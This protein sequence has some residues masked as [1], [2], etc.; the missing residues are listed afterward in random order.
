MNRTA[1]ESRLL[2]RIRQQRGSASIPRRDRSAPAPLSF[3]QLRL[4]LLERLTPQSA[5]YLI[6]CAFRVHGRLDVSALETAFYGL[7]QR[8]EVLRT[9]YEMVGD[10]PVQV[11]DTAPRTAVKF[12]DICGEADPDERER[13]AL[14]TVERDATLGFDL[15]VDHPLRVTAVRLSE[16]E[17]LLL[18]AMHH[19]AVDGW[20]MEILTGELRELY[21]AALTGRPA[22]LTDLAVQYADYA[23]WQRNWLVG[24]VLERQLSYWRDRLANLEPLEMPTDWPRPSERSGAGSSLEF[25]VPATVV[26][27]LADIAAAQGC[28]LFM[29]ALASFQIVLSRWSGQDDIAVGSPIAGRNRAES[30]G[31]IGFFVNTLVLRT[32]LSGEPTFVELLGKVRETALDAYN[33]QDLPFER[34]VEELS[35]GRDLSRNPLFQIGFVLQGFQEISWQLPGVTMEPLKIESEYSK[36]DLLLALDELSNGE[37]GGEITFSTELFEM[38]TAQSFAT[39]YLCVLEQVTADPGLRIGHIDLLRAD[40]RRQFVSDW[41]DTVVEIPEATAPQLFAAQVAAFPDA[42]AVVFGDTTLTYAELDR[43]ANRLAHWLIEQGVGIEDRVAVL[44]PRSIELVVALL[45]VTKAGGAF[46]PLHPEW[47]TERQDWI[48]RQA[49]VSVVIAESRPDVT[50]SYP[51]TS[52]SVHVRP[53]QLVYVMYTSGSTGEPKGVA[54]RHRDVAALVMDRCWRGEVHQRVLV[55]SAHS[56]DASTYEMWVPLLNGGQAVLAPVG[57]LNA[58]NLAETITAAEITSL[59]LTTRLFELIADEDPGVFTGVHEV[60]T[61]GEEMPAEAVMRAVTACP[62]TRFVHVYGPTETTTFA[63]YHRINELPV[64]GLDVPI[65]RPLDNTRVF[66]LDSWLRLVPPGVVGELYVAGAGLARGYLGRSGLTAGRF[67]ADPFGGA[68]K[69]LYRTGDRVRW[70][71]EGQLVFVG[72]AD[73]QVKVRGFR[74]E[75]GEVEAALT[76]HVSVAQA[77]VVA[78]D[79]DAGKR[80]VGYVVPAVADVGVDTVVVREFVSARLPEY[81]V[82][83]ALVVLE[84]LPL[85]VNGKVDRKALPEPVFTGGVYRGPR[86]PRE[87]LLC[88]VFAEVLGVERVGIDDSFFDL[89]GHSLLATKLVSRVRAVLGV[90]PT[91]R[92]VFDAPTVAVLAGRLADTGHARAPLARMPRPQRVPLSFAQRRLWFLDQFEGP[93]AIYNMPLVMRLIGVLDVVGLQ[94]AVSDVV[95]RHESLRTII[96]VVDGEP[97]QR[98][99]TDVEP[100]FVVAEVDRSRLEEELAQAAAHTFDL[101]EEIP[102]R[103]WLWQTGPQEHVLA[104][105]IHHI[106]GDGWSLVP[107]LRDLSRAYAARSTGRVPEFVELPVQYA[108]YA[109]WQQELLGDEDDPGSVFGRQLE[110]WRHGLQGAPAELALPYDRSRPVVPTHRG[111][112]VPVQLDAQIHGEL[113]KLARA[114]DVTMFML[115]NAALA[116]LLSRMGGGDDIPVGAAMAGRGDEALDDLVGFFVNT[117]VLRTDL[118]GDPSFVEVLE[119]VREVNLG[120]HAHADVPF[121][122]V[123]DALGVE[124]SAARQP[125][126][127]VMLMLQNNAQADLV[128]PGL[129]LSGH[130][131]QTGVAKFDLTFSFAETSDQADTVTGLA[132]GVEYATDLFDHA[133]I[134]ALAERFTRVLQAVVTDPGLPVS[135]I[136]ILSDHERQQLRDWNDTVVEIPE[137]TAPQLFAAQV[138]AFP[139]AVAVVFGDT[140]LTYAELDRRANRLA[141]WL[142]EQGVGIED[143]VAVLLPRSIELVVALLAVTK[144]G[145]VYVPVDPDLPEERVKFVMHDAAPVVVVDT[146]FLTRDLDGYPDTEPVVAEASEERAVYVIYT[147]GSTGTPKGVVV[148]H[149]ALT[150]FLSAMQHQFPMARNDRFLAITTVSFD[151]AALEI[152]LPLISG[153]CVVIA[154]REATLDPR[155]VLTLIRQAGI[156]VMQATPAYW[157]VLVGHDCDSLNGLRVLTGGE[158]LPSPLAATMRE[159]AAEATNMYGPTET[160][161]WSMLWPITA[162]RAIPPIGKPIANTRI[163]VLDGSLRP[164][165]LGVSGELYVA[166]A[167]LARGYLGRAGLT[168]ARFV[169]DPFA[170]E[171]GGRL[172]RTGDLVRWSQDGQLVFVGRA[173]D[174]V[175]L[176]GFRIEPGEVETVLATHR[177]VRQA[178]VVAR[179]SDSGKR[180]VGYVVPAVAEVGVDT[181]AVRE[182]AAARLPEYMVPAALVVLEALPLNPNGK[183]DRKALPEPVFTG[184]VYRGPKTVREELLCGVFAEVLGAERVGIDDNFF[185]LGGHS[186]A[187]AKLVNRIR[188]VFDVELAL[189]EV[190]GSPTVAGLAQRID[191]AESA[192]PPVRA[193]TPRPE[194]IP[195]SYAQR[196]LWFIDQMDHIGAAYNIPFAARLGGALDRN[197]LRQAVS[198]VVNRHETLRTIFPMLDGEPIQHILDTAAA[199]TALQHHEQQLTESELEQ[200]LADVTSREF[201]LATE[202]PIRLHVFALGTQDHVLVLV[203]HHIAGDGWSVGPLMSDLA[204]AYEARCSGQVPAWEPLPV[205]YTDYI[206]WQHEL[207]GSESNPDSLLTRQLQFWRTTL[208]GAPEELA[209]PT[210][211]PRPAFQSYNGSS[212]DFTIDAE[213]HNALERLSRTHGAT[214]FMT[215][216]AGLAVLLTRLGSGTDLPIG[217]AVAGRGDQSLDGLVGF[218]VNTLVLRTDTSGDPTFTELLE[219][220]RETDLAAF[221]NQEVPFERV[222]EELNPTRATARH[223]LFQV[224]LLLENSTP[225]EFDFAGI[226]SLPVPTIFDNAKFDLLIGLT[227]HRTPEST[228]NGILGSIN[229]SSDLFDRGSAQLIAERF[230]RTLAAVVADPRSRVSQIDLL[231][232]AERRRMLLEWN[233]TATPNSGATLPELFAAQVAATPDATALRFED[234]TLTYTELNARANRLARALIARGAGPGSVVGVAIHRSV[235]LVVGIYATV[236]AGAAYLPINP[237]HPAD[238]IAGILEQANPLFV[239]TATRDGLTLPSPTHRLDIDTHDLSAVSGHAIRT[240]E[241]RRLLSPDHLAYVLFTSG[242]TGKPKG[243]GVSHAA[244]V[245]QLRWMQHE[246]PLDDSDVVV[247]KTSATFDVSVLEFFAPLL[248][249]AQLVVAAPGG[250]RDPGYLAT[251]IAKYGVT[252]AHFVP[253]MLSLFVADA[254]ARDCTSLRRVFCAGEALTS[255]TVRDFHT[256]LGRG[257]ELHNLYG[258]TEASVVVTAWPCDPDHNSVPIGGPSWNTQLYVLDERLRPVPPGV[259]GELYLAGVQLA[260]GYVGQPGLSAERFVANPFTVDARMYRTGDLVRWRANTTTGVLEYLGRA[261]FQVKLRG[262]RIELTEIEVVLRRHEDIER[263]AVVV[264]TDDHGNQRLIAY[265]VAA[266]ADQ[267]HIEQVRAHAA[268]TLPGYMVPSA[269]I[270]LTELPLNSNGKLDRKALPAPDFSELV[271]SRGPRTA[272]EE[273]LC[274]LF[275]EVLELPTVGID[276]NFFDLGGHSLLG[277]RLMTRLGAALGVEVPLHTLFT[278]PTV[279]RLAAKLDEAN[280]TSE[281][282]EQR[283]GMS[284][285][286]R[287][288]SAATP[289]SFAQLRLWLLDCLMPGSSAYVIASAFRVRGTL[290][291]EALESA[292]RAVA[293]RHEALRT[294]YVVTADEPVQVVDAEP[295]VTLRLVEVS[296]E[297][298]VSERDRIA[299]AAIERDAALAFDLMVDHPVRVTVARL[300]Q[301]EHLLLVALHHIAADG[302][303]MEILTRELATY[304]EAA[305]TGRAAELAALPVQYADYAAWQRNWLTGE[306]LNRQLGYWRERLADL[307]PLE[308]PT[309][310]SRPAERSGAGDCLRF[311][312]PAIAGPLAAIA[313]EQGSSLFMAT[314]AAFTIVLSRWSSQDDIAVGSPIAGRTRAETED[315][316]GFFVNTLVLRTDTSGDPTFTELLGRVRDATLGAYAHQDLPFERLVEELAPER[317][318]SRNPLFQIS[319]AFQ[320]FQEGRWALP[321]ADIEPVDLETTTSKFDLLIDLA[322]RPD[323]GL[324]GG[325]TFSTELFD[326]ATVRRLAGHYARVLEQVTTD[327]GL[328]IGQI[329]LIAEAERRDVLDEWNDTTHRLPD[330]TVVELFT[331]QARRRPDATAVIFADRELTYHQLHS[332]AA[333]LTRHLIDNGV[334]PGSIVAIAMPRSLEMMVALLGVLATGAA[335][336]PIDPDHPAERIRFMLTDAQPVVTITTTDTK[337]ILPNS[338]TLDLSTDQ[339]DT[340]AT[341]LPTEIHPHHLAY[342]IYTSGSTGTPKAVGIAHSGLT[343][344]LLWMQAQYQ[345]TPADRVIQKTPYGFDVSVWEFFWPMITGATL[346]MAAP[347]GHRD[348]AYLAQLIRDRSVTV[349]HF[350]PSMLAVFLDEPSAAEC[351]SVR[352]LTCSGEALPPDLRDRCLS[353][354]TTAEFHNLYG[355]TEASIDVTYW[356]CRHDPETPTVPIGRPL[357]NTR[358]YV[359]DRN[360]RPVPPGVVGML[361]VAGTGLARGYLNRPGLT[362]R[363]FVPNLFGSP[364]T[365]LY[366][367]GDLAR[368]HPRGYLEY[369]GRADD[370]VK[371]RGVRIEL[372]EIETTLTTHPHITQAAVLVQGEKGYQQLAAYLVPGGDLRSDPDRAT[373]GARDHLARYLP[374]YLIPDTFT[375]LDRMPLNPNGKLDRRALPPPDRTGSRGRPP[376]SFDEEALAELFAQ[377]LD[378][379]RVDV[380]DSFFALGGHSLLAT[381]LVSRIQMVLGADVSMRTLFEA[382]TVEALAARLRVG[383]R[384]RGLSEPLVLNANGARPPLFCF[385]PWVGISWCYAT[386]VRSLPADQPVYG[387]QS[388]GLDDMRTMPRSIAEAAEHHAAEIRS[389]RPNGP[390]LLL[391]WSFGGVVAHAVAARLQQQGEQVHLLALLDSHPRDAG[392]R[393]PTPAEHRDALLTYSKLDHDFVADEAELV[394]VLSEPGSA[395]AALNTDQRANLVAVSRNNLRIDAG[396]RA[397][398]FHGDILLFTAERTHDGAE[399]ARKWQSHVDG[400]VKVVPLDY[401]HGDMTEPRAAALVGAA[402]IEELSTGAGQTQAG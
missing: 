132:G 135:A 184:G 226:Q 114:H 228:P 207:L 39:R 351:T 123:V 388:R 242:S 60:W 29:A 225:D 198:D 24:E 103:A 285:P 64:R 251:L 275:A 182:F 336:L 399:T 243:V 38:A 385:A 347:D 49:A 89:G 273:V 195:L 172:Y 208:A 101:A 363:R 306:V 140:T 325:L 309:D 348:P 110:Y 124:R 194:P 300:A 241:R 371:I 281:A 19:I 290:D 157:Q 199:E 288:P 296:G 196:R 216:Q 335:Y 178:V 237:D 339:I 160:T 17:H 222:V 398:V 58:E 245:N 187:A 220:V 370:Q 12:I 126:F 232:E 102:L 238:R 180:L 133:T 364:G 271:S 230:V 393:P 278:A 79:S 328:R 261:D 129:T 57:T 346:V 191:S 163:F 372:G 200:A 154:S 120:A 310:R 26:R 329:D 352:L 321:G 234:E 333:Q 231:T 304:Y 91:L 264:H 373:R 81:M 345:L 366:D 252:T 169:A 40:E 1:V 175:K 30:E 155:S 47:P 42:V 401:A 112:H 161:I 59:F 315:L 210:D 268:A 387:L 53:D 117:V 350:V 260:R 5:E 327:P 56:F 43:R 316:I 84:A 291:V 337:T 193:V 150:N 382:P 374:G 41:N 90:E 115:L 188:M 32:D 390:Y 159:R 134:A 262:Q 80:L 94:A 6:P 355:P 36:F 312:V 9:R 164:V 23:A 202:L 342:I 311:E 92:M 254:K 162:A 119:R 317:D 322:E 152:F 25:T 223:P 3:A 255:D 69:R 359:L 185:D 392:Y 283:A 357:W 206:M 396:H 85:N 71:R 248:T 105:V 376:R 253:S 139:D 358:A 236:Q 113:L 74:I 369:R 383:E 362:A 148:S 51:H 386:L 397:E 302:W 87:E 83:A 44:L 2:A 293:R 167:G 109:L 144:A 272:R 307:E 61:G 250:H 75:P 276:D 247:Q 211:R 27:R 365:R 10:E 168:S 263:A 96:E 305:R 136:S 205:Q 4:W 389:I 256:A 217:S 28:S 11:I 323:G 266:T 33:H 378:V 204:T 138:A 203:L 353:M 298:D 349:A 116:V 265:L 215:M 284:I 294:R 77:V 277:V 146:A 177:G 153:A 340:T 221:N 214:I 54:V 125:L 381:R 338:I 141:H 128:L 270:S 308:L 176:R 320:N 324:D 147:S 68:G 330:T 295:R 218:F 100:V 380:S 192:R 269:F 279:A 400:I 145:G 166:G 65:G 360:L 67:V 88:G 171:P 86:T 341:D 367:T 15:A 156:T 303:S 297:P 318:L 391:G 292:F 127:Q 99:L 122:R 22:A 354:F 375:V 332:R 108:D 55:H 48:C 13:L 343:N 173:D 379:E 18:V 149:A 93:N 259:V 190:F 344:R 209:L 287:D 301:D 107:L 181:V 34:L 95:A 143:R 280:S 78:R 361:F 213:L 258:P 82:P 267:L 130:E 98:I 8:H 212:I 35:P 189:R 227:E 233:D 106:A 224:M 201:D 257:P 197:A 313:A 73:D 240:Q 282:A 326:E 368:W 286:H 20:S 249:G 104:V 395:F 235:D 66:V 319:F 111:G 76:A 299:L 384:P 46:V 186:L 131:A 72:R 62:T 45:A 246:Y 377:A 229:Y 174:Q 151:I 402:L 165:P 97:G 170:L 394:D 331:R 70:N 314:L 16:D 50:S 137:A 179:D 31:L 142:I 289:L 334:G 21:S 183:V 158:V 239:L 356:D 7:A 14:T 121:E 219:R 52:P 37:L 118:S 244:I 63:T 274:S